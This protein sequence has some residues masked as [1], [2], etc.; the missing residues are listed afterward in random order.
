MA[1]RLTATMGGAVAALALV[2]VACGGSSSGG[3]GTASG[4]VPSGPPLTKAPIKIG[5]VGSYTGTAG[6][7][8]KATADAVQAWA[9]WT[10]A[11][12][13][14]DGHPVQVFVKDDAGSTTRAVAAV[15]ELVET[16]HVIAIVGQHESGLET[17]WEKYIDDKKIP[18]IGGPN[19]S[20]AWLIDPNFFPTS[21]TPVNTLTLTAYATKLAGKNSYGMVYCAEFPACAQGP[22][23][24]SSLVPKL[25]EKYA[26]AIS[27][28]A[29]APNYTAQCLA[30]R[31]DG[32][33]AVFTATS[34]DAALRFVQDC[35]KQ[36]YRPVW[37][38]NPENSSADQFAE[39]ALDGTWLAADSFSWLSTRPGA[40]QFNQAMAAFARKTPTNTSGTAG[41]AA[42]TVF[43]AAAAHISATPTSNDIY[44]GLYALGA[45]YT[46][47]GI[48]PPVTF[49]KGKPASQRACGW[50]LR[51]MN[52]KVTSPRGGDAVC[53]DG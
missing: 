52:R 8:S 1:R 40:I 21:T 28:S 9:K 31:S 48:I 33:K 45:D 39:P 3:S 12:G 34:Q 42:A 32:A 38:D 30:L 16:D 50:Y 14:I 15:R 26:G 36:G 44:T 27:I 11:H 6:S 24:S 46:A 37:I 29:S 49:A 7:T 41:W 23:L 10:N 2:L 13:G 53:I 47:G 17:S 18:V 19:E 4:S 5:N 51:I 35:T 22:R 20:A 25:G 43:G